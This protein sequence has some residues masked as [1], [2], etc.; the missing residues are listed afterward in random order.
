MW[1]YSGPSDSDYASSEDL[2]DDEVWSH[3]GRVLQLKPREKVEGRPA[4]FNSSIVSTLGLGNYKSRPHL[5]KGPEGMA[6]QAAQK[7]AADTRK[8]KK[9]E[10]AHRKHK[11]E[12]EVAR[13]V[14]VGERKSDVE[15]E[16][17]SEDPTDV[18]NMV[19][20]EE[21]R[22]REAVVTL[23]ERR[24]LAATS[25]GDE[26]EATLYRTRKSIFLPS[27]SQMRE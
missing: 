4:S 12:K 25:A 24:I 23:A 19:F 10:V 15:A 8:K 14:K 26:Q 22:S 1:L 6:K 13:H 18:D 5:P 20:S 27:R 9:A 16:L 7:E 17:K 21:E 2:P 11:K 3:L